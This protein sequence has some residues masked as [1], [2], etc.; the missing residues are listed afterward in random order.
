[1]KPAML[2]ND[3]Q[4]FKAKILSWLAGSKQIRIGGFQ[5]CKVHLCI[6]KDFKDTACQSWCIV[7]GDLE[8][9]PVQKSSPGSTPG[10]RK[11]CINFDKLYLWSPLEYKDVL[12]IFGNLQTLSVW[13]QLV[14]TISLLWTLENYYQTYSTLQ[15][16]STFCQFTL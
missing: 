2:G 13:S 12:Y 1:M 4:A 11:Q 10:H 3:F 14:R 8:L 5:K 9:N 16:N 6:L 15:K 7:C